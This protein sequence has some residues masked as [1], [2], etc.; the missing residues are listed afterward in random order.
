[1]A[2][3]T[4]K[5][6]LLAY[7]TGVPYRNPFLLAKA[8]ATLDALSEGRVDLAMIAGHVKAEFLALGVEF[9]QRNTLFDQALDVMKLAW[10]GRPVSYEGVGIS[11]RG[12]T[13][14]PLPVQQPHPRLWFDGSSELTMRRVV[15]HGAGWMPHVNTSERAAH[16]PPTVDDLARRPGTAAPEPERPRR[17]LV[18]RSR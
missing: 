16:R 4:T 18:E 10:T 13:A 2:A 15:E 7:L 17:P 1:M 8:V 12:V 3:A 14:H 5:L 11:A 6:R 9:E